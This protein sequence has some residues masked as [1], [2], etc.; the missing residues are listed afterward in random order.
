VLAVGT[1]AL[2]LAAMSTGGYVAY[3][4]WR[5]AQRPD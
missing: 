2:I 3:R 4:W 1:M 5:R